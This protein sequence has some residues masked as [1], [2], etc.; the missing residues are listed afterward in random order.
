MRRSPPRLWP[1]QCPPSTHPGRVSQGIADGLRLTLQRCR[2]RVWSSPLSSLRVVGRLRSPSAIGWHGRGS[3]TWWPAT[4]R[5][6]RPR[7][8]RARA[9]PQRDRGGGVAGPAGPAQG[10]Q[11][12]VLTVQRVE[13]RD[14]APVAAP[15]RRRVDGPSRGQAVVPDPGRRGH[16]RLSSPRSAHNRV[17]SYDQDHS[18]SFPGSPPTGDGVT[19]VVRFEQASLRS[20][21]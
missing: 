11:D 17:R 19:S 4:R 14:Q 10:V 1:R 21:G 3:M 5:R 12:V 9:G 15:G 13:L 7:S 8:S 6:V 18:A 2:R 20:G 16:C